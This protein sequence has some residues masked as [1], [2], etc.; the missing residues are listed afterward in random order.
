M[1]GAFSTQG[2]AFGISIVF[3]WGGDIRLEGFWPS[4]LLLTI[5]I[6]AV[7]IVVA[8]VVDHNTLLFDPLASGLS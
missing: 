8:V 6:V 2:K 7:A 5:I 3:S 4:I 1:Q